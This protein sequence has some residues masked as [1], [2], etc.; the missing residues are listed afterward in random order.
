MGADVPGALAFAALVVVEMQ[1][2][3]LTPVQMRAWLQETCRDIVANDALT[4]EEKDASIR[5]L[6][7][8]FGYD[9]VT[10]MSDVLPEASEN[11][12]TWVLRPR[13]VH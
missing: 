7:V 10:E 11:G 13:R 12:G 2:R 4:F 8:L 1:A 6:A 3:G 5:G 9:V